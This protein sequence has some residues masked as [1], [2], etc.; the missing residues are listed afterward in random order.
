MMAD[1][2]RIATARRGGRKP[3]HH[4]VR[5]TIRRMPGVSL[6]SDTKRTMMH[7]GGN[8]GGFMDDSTHPAPK[9]VLLIDADPATR[10]LVRPLLAPHGLD[11]IQAR[12]SV[13][14]LEILQRL[15]DRFRLAM[16]N[17]EM[18]GLSGAVL[19]ETLRLCRPGF[20][21]VCLSSAEPTAVAAAG[22]NCLSRPFQAAELRIQVEEALAGIHQSVTATAVDREALARAKAAFDLSGNL[23]DAAQELSRGMPSEPGSGW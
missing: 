18:P 7:I 11:V 19:I 20:P 12:N 15:A 22:S 8:N 21:V 2:A 1:R 3:L 4:I 23:L 14:G 10:G 5:V 6:P 16:I 17:V 9:L 13:A